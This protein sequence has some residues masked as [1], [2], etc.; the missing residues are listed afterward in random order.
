[1]VRSRKEILNISLGEIYLTVSSCRH[2]NMYINLIYIE[3]YGHRHPAELLFLE[4]ATGLKCTSI[5]RV[6]G[7]THPNI[8][9]HQMGLAKLCMFPSTYMCNTNV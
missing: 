9:H 3:G 7:G 5:F 8:G 1:M 4:P 2:L 6:L